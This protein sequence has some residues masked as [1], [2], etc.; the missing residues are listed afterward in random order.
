MFFKTVIAQ[1]ER[2]AKIM[3]LVNAM[4]K[5]F[6]LTTTVEI[7]RKSTAHQGILSSMA[8]QV[9]DCG[10]FIRD[11]VEDKAFC[12]IHPVQSSSR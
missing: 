7:W 11:Y 12:K 8:Q 2:D 9:T 3:D 5:L 10:Y 6:A 4:N 1:I